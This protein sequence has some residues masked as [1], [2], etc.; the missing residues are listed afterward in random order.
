MIKKLMHDPIF[1]AGKSEVATK[2]DLQVAQDLLDTLMAHR[3]SCVGM[4]ANMI[5]VHKRIIAFLDE[6]GRAPAYTVMLNPE[7]IKK[8]D[9]YDTE[10][11]CLSLPGGS[12]A[13]LHPVGNTMSWLPGT[14]ISRTK[15]SNCFP[16]PSISF[17]ISFLAARY[18]FEAAVLTRSPEKT[19][20]TSSMS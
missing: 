19:R 8:D 17:P 14:I 4:A 15:Q 2:E 13:S 3:E 7:I 9:A 1:L 20:T 11:G 6:S 5:G 16:K 18:S 12:D 10:E